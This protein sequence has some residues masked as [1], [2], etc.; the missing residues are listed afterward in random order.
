M[1]SQD[2]QPKMPQFLQHLRDSLKLDA[3]RLEANFI[4]ASD[5]VQLWMFSAYEQERDMREMYSIRNR[6]LECNLR[7]VQDVH[8][9]QA[10]NRYCGV[11][12]IITAPLPRYK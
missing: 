11:S 12:L 10:N 7:V 9:L 3:D 6:L 8:L 2:Q 1:T 5:Y 4:E